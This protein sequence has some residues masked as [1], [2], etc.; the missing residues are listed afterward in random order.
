MTSY[1]INTFLNMGV[2]NTDH[3]ITRT[4]NRTCAGGGVGCFCT[5]FLEVHFLSSDFVSLV[6]LPVCN[7]T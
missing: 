6:Q 3:G 1:P 4:V 7:F 5:S 2:L